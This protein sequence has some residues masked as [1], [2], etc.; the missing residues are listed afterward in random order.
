MDRRSLHKS[1]MESEVLRRQ[2]T[3]SYLA[4]KQKNT[5]G[6]LTES[7]PYHEQTR[8][9]TSHPLALPSPPPHRYVTR[10]SDRYAPP[11]RRPLS[12]RKHF[13]N[14]ILDAE[15]NEN[16]QKT[17]EIVEIQPKTTIQVIK[18]GVMVCH[19]SSRLSSLAHI[20]LTVSLLCTHL[21]RWTH[22]VFAC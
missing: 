1:R 2:E 16:I 10:H 22:V 17:K 6:G 20:S 12:G 8:S 11:M 14:I 3:S 15:K 9:V 21:S 4:I 13:A 18:D 19:L 7:E 5:A